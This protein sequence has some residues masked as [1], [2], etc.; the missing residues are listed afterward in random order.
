MNYEEKIEYAEPVVIE[1]RLMQQLIDPGTDVRPLDAKAAE[2]FLAEY[3]VLRFENPLETQICKPFGG[4]KET[5]CVTASAVKPSKRLMRLSTTWTKLDRNNGAPNTS[6]TVSL[7]RKLNPFSVF[8]L[9][10]K[11][12][13]GKTRSMKRKWII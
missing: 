12:F 10:T 1:K 3:E 2:K 9:S 13:R 5:E 6:K 11:T 8:M 7:G 4:E